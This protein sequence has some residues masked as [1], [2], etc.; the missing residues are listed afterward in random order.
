MNDKK[1]GAKGNIQSK[2]K[3]KTITKWLALQFKLLF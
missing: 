1:L 3:M 2:Y